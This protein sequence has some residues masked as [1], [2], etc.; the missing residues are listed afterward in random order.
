M[1]KEKEQ[2]LFPADYRALLQKNEHF[3]LKGV[4]FKQPASNDGGFL[5]TGGSELSPIEMA[6]L[7]I[8]QSGKPLFDVNSF[9]IKDLGNNTALT[10]NFGVMQGAA[11]TF[12]GYLGV[13]VTKTYGFGDAQDDNKLSASL[14]VGGAA[15]LYTDPNQPKDF[16]SNYEWLVHGGYFTP[17]ARA[18]V[19]YQNDNYEHGPYALASFTKPLVGTVKQ[20]HDGFT[21]H[22]T[23]FSVLNVQTG[24]KHAFELWDMPFG[25][26]IGA[27]ANLGKQDIKVKY[28]DP[29]QPD[30]NMNIKFNKPLRVN[31]GVTVDF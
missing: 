5:G 10:G 6:S 22:D 30:V 29:S 9:S 15:N 7:S 28:D 31:L 26:F 1:G 24:F 3:G 20:H 23:T 12:S 27:Q 11:S 14:T 2:Q 13:G 17:A 21:E 18:T 16:A 4:Q 19:I 25:A 8:N